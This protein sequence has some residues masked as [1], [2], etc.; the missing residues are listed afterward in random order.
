MIPEFYFGDDAVLLAADREGI[1][2]FKRAL[3]DAATKQNMPADLISEGVKHKFV[4][5]RSEARVELQ[6]ND[7]IWHLPDQKVSEI[8]DKLASLKA[9]LDPAHH[10]VD[11]DNP[12]RTLILSVDEYLDSPIFA[13][14]G[15]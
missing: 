15:I 14:H 11:I 2:A 12:A 10:Y 4:L 6:E 8:L 3:S 5:G 9:G 7:V 13:S 1:D